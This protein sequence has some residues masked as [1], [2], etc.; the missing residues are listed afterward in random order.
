MWPS[1]RRPK[2]IV[3]TVQ[4]I[5]AADELEADRRDARGARISPIGARATARLSSARRL[6]DVASAYHLAEAEILA[7]LGLRCATPHCGAY[8]PPAQRTL[9]FRLARAPLSGY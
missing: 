1:N 4:E 3:Q 7:S 9:G 2:F 6:R 5:S 8:A